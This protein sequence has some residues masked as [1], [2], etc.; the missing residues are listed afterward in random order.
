MPERPDAVDE[1]FM[2]QAVAASYAVRGRTS[3]NPPVGAI[4][5]SPEGQVV[6]RGATQPPGQAHAEVVA[7]AEAGD[8]ARGA[9]AYVT[10]EPCNHVGRTG[11]CARALIASG[12]AE[13]VYAAPDPNPRS[14]GGAGSLE[15]AGVRVRSGVLADE[16]SAG[17]LR[18]WLHRQRTGRPHVTWKFAATLDGRI[19]AKDGTSQWITGPQ[20][21]E[22]VHA[23]RAELDAIIVGTGTALVDD[24]W[25]TARLP[26]GS[27]AP[28]QPT[29]VVVGRSE[30]SAG[31]RVL[32]DA[33][34]TILA[35]THDPA[36]ALAMLGDAVHVLLEGGPTLAAAF[37]KA[38][39]VDLVQAHVAPALLGAG[40]S[41]VG[42]LG[43]GTLADALR[44]TVE[45]VRQAG[46]DIVVRLV[47]RNAP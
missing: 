8:R 38:G 27:L 21:R 4:L 17:P 1:E 3:P 20:A 44:F 45:D 30:L 43:I 31:A 26:D 2:R 34:P 12:I 40:P 18:E 41:A 24:P 39:L 32:D 42:D 5:V 28:H 11:P 14:S 7:L 47:P 23:M 16:V 35:K 13:V 36:E 6:G 25:L 37:L 22:S 10:L 9:T 29:R 15:A 46:E 33:A 19:A